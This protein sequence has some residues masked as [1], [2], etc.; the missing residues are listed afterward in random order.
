RVHHSGNKYRRH[1][2]DQTF[3]SLQ[4]SV[5]VFTVGSGRDYRRTRSRK[6]DSAESACRVRHDAALGTVT[7]HRAFDPGANLHSSQSG[8]SCALPARTKSERARKH[9]CELVSSVLLI[10]CE[11]QL[12]NIDSGVTEDAEITPIN[13]L[14]DELADFVFF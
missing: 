7:F 5:R 1:D 8:L 6:G 11:I 2:R 9:S 14:V 12:K 10:Q 13:V 4:I 3:L